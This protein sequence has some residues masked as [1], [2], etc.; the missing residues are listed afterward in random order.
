M[1]V[2]LDSDWVNTLTETLTLFVQPLHGILNVLNKIEVLLGGIIDALDF[3]Y[4]HQTFVRHEGC[5][6][7]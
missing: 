2:W 5:I 1:I 4:C 6:L 3:R 7:R